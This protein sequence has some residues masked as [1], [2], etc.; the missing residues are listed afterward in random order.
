MRRGLV[1]VAVM[2]LVAGS[3]LASRKPT[4]TENKDIRQAFAGFVSQPN[5]PSAK[6]NR[7]VTIAVSTLD[8]RYAVARLNSKTAGPSE[9][10]LHRSGPGWWVVGFGSS[11]GCDSAPPTVM[12]DLKV[13]C[14]PP[15]GVA[16]INN[17]GPLVSAPRELVLACG[18][19]NYLLANLRWRG[20]GKPSATATGVA[21]A[22]T[23]TPNCAS[24]KFRSYRMTAT[25]SK[26]SACGKARYYA[27]LTIVY[28][29]A[30]PQG[31]A[32]R[33][34]HTLGC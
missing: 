12:R 14:S 6:D 17:C 11:L 16:W 7:I 24:G 33:D 21:R 15:N 4:A 23:C 2:L 26:L 13:G 1:L 28:P 34:V 18:D 19:A 31:I 27:T 22:N 9:L 10:L 25:A 20:W 32:K 30:R 8:P 29:G 5:S 3:A